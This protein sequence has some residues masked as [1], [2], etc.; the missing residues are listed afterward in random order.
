MCTIKVV[1]TPLFSLKAVSLQRASTVGTVGR[2]Y[3]SRTGPA[4]GVNLQL[5]SPDDLLQHSIS[6]PAVVTRQESDKKRWINQ[7][8]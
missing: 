4:H 2:K 1:K 7:E 8:H 5:W 3:I 6:D